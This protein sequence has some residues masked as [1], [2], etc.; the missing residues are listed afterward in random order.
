MRVDDLLTEKNID[1]KVTGRDYVVKC[2]NP[3]HDDKNP[4]M[5]IDQVTGIFHCF[6]CGFR[7]NVFNHFGA[8]ANFL[9]I[10]RQKLKLISS[11]CW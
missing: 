9:E 8:V 1:F 3:E 4:S 10:K 6:S 11:N 5:R 7:G 2:L